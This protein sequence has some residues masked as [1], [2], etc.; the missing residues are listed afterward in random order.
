MA[1][2]ADRPAIERAVEQHVAPRGRLDLLVNCRPGTPPILQRGRRVPP[3][4]VVRKVLRAVERRRRR[5]YVPA[6]VRLIAVLEGLA[7][8]LLDW[9]GARFGITQR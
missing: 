2:V 3:A 4:I 5:V 6:S 7:P 8:S 1:G 9:Y